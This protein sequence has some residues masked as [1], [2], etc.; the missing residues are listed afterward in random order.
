MNDLLFSY[1]ADDFT[2]ATDALE[3][4]CA[5]GVNTVL[6]NKPP[7]REM[8]ARYQGV[9]AVGVAG[10]T[11][12]MA[13]ASMRKELS[14]VFPKLVELGAGHI[15]YKVCST[16]D[17]S[18]E[19]GSIGCAMEVGR[20]TIS[21]DYIPL[22]VGVPRLGRYC[23]FGNLFATT[24]IGRNRMV[25]RLD[26]HPSASNHPST[27]MLESD[28]RAHLSHQTELCSSL[29]DLRTFELEPEDQLIEL[30]RLLVEG[31]EVVVFDV[32]EDQHLERIGYLLESAKNNSLP[33]FSVGSSAIEYALV[34]HW[35]HSGTIERLTSEFECDSVSQTLVV[36]GS[37]SPVTQSQIEW[38]LRN[39]FQEVQL[40][41][42][43]IFA[44]RGSAES[45]AKP[46]EE[47]V[48]L[49]RTGTS[50]IVHASGDQHS[51]SNQK[52]VQ[53]EILSK[54]LGQITSSALAA[55]SVT[56]VCLCGGDTSSIAAQE[57][58]IESIAMRAPLTPGAPLCEV[59]APG[60]PADQKEFVFKGGQVGRQDFF[61]QL[62]EGT[63]LSSTTNIFVS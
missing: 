60:L 24:S 53:S 1:Y 28:L 55:T 56:R 21:P 62:L 4:L 3:C 26:R 57:L 6:F 36:S 54:S 14:R 58:G 41:T 20:E 63:S 34:A 30:K 27:P 5:A 8:L 35:L 43:T 23:A 46:I 39:G 25:Y 2:G 51:G 19:L 45:L 32:V 17:S 10:S 48:N 12:S 40:D 31:A 59:S 50:T 38:A 15:H 29:L 37:R 7:T 16:F 18:P 11:R 44:E 61:G 9:Q 42:A 13:P 49:L 33:L 47:L 22:V 52:S